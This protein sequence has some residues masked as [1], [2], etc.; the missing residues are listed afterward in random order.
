MLMNNSEIDSR[1]TSTDN[2]LNRM[3]LAPSFKSSDPVRAM[4]L[5]TGS[6]DIKSASHMHGMNTSSRNGPAQVQGLPEPEVTTDELARRV[7][8][9]I[10]IGL[11]K[12]S[13]RAVIGDSLSLLQQRLQ[14]V[15]KPEKFARIAADMGKVIESFTP[16]N[17][18]VQR[19]NIVIYRP[20][21]NHISSYQVVHANE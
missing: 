1:L 5:F 14:E 2:L 12:N 8:D 20:V 6:D 21:V 3:R 19:G 18:Q 13:A 11:I 4:E 7:E 10:K 17:E 16:K 9:E 15:D